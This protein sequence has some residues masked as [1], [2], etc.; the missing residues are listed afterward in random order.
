MRAFLTL[1]FASALLIFLGSACSRATQPGTEAAP[2]TLVGAGA[3]L[4]YP[5]YSKWA[6]EYARVDPTVRVNYQS[7]GS[8]AGVRQVSDGVVDFGATDEP[9]TEDQLR[10]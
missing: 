4:P 2:R 9:M 3:T 8:G 1:L 10:S 6:S 5:L 7:I